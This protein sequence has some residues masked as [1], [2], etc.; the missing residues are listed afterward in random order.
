M[1][2]NNDLISVIIPAYNHEKYVQASIWSAINQTYK[3]LELIV[4]DDGSTDNTWEKI[5]ELREECE[6]RFVRFFLKRQKNS[7]TIKVLDDT[8]RIAQGKYI[9][10]IASDDIAHP[11]AI[12]I[13]HRNIG[14]AGM[15][16]PDVA[17][18]DSMGKQLFLNENFEAVYDINEAK[19]KTLHEVYINRVWPNV[20]ST[21]FDFYANL[22]S[23]NYINIGFLLLKQAAIDAGGW[24]K[25]VIIEDYYMYLQVAKRY[26]I[27]RIK[28]VLFFYRRHSNN[29]SNNSL[30]MQ[31]GVKRIF[32]NEKK[33]CYKNRYKKEWNK[34][35]RER[36]YSTSTYF[37]RLKLRILSLYYGLFK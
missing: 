18:I 30:E 33:Y 17:W 1:S 10:Y 32:M 27:K 21:E 16:F 14:D 24:N 31:E 15:V 19:Y 3:N 11:N 9:Y 8:L 2:T 25:D 7:K 29:R 12:E 34:I 6:N 36:Y 37:D 13:L 5:N 26:K 22:I 20:D 28:D 4:V 23:G 35:F